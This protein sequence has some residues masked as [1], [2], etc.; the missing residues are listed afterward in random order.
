MFKAVMYP[1]TVTAL[2]DLLSSIGT[3]PYTENL[4]RVGLKT[5]VCGIDFQNSAQKPT[6]ITE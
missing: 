4:L 6:N 5:R 2:H 3:K 1:L